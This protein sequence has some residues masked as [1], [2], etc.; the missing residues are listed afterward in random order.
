MVPVWASP[1]TTFPDKRI[2]KKQINLNRFLKWA[3][4]PQG[5]QSG[6]AV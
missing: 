6:A 2:M 5:Y 3:I 4:E 1:T